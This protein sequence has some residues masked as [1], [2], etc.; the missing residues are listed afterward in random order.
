MYMLSWF[1]LIKKQSFIL[2]MNKLLIKIGKIHFYGRCKYPSLNGFR[3]YSVFFDSVNMENIVH[4][5]NN[6]HSL[7]MRKQLLEMF[8]KCISFR[9]I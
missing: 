8:S 6:I 5:I 3:K 7:N 4:S 1:E 9:I 2:S